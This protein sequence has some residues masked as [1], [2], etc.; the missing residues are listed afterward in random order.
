DGSDPASLDTTLVVRTPDFTAVDTNDCPL[1]RDQYEWIRDTYAVDYAFLGY[2]AVSH[3]P[4]SFEMDA[5]AKERLLEEAAERHYA[6]FVE[7]A[8]LLQARLTVP[9][10]NGMRFLQPDALWRNVAFNCAADAAER[11]R[12]AGLPAEVM[13][14]GDRIEADGA[15]TR[16]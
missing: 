2:S 5:G 4:L 10:A 16:V 6:S 8:S 1:R 13:G 7:A 9:F 12:R 15:L 11:A 3:Y 14:P